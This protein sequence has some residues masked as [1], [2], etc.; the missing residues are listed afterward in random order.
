MTVRSAKQATKPLVCGD[1]L[2]V[3]R[4]ATRSATLRS[5]DHI[6][7]VD[8]PSSRIDESLQFVAKRF[9]QRVVLDDL[10]EHGHRVVV[11]GMPELAGRDR[12]FPCFRGARP[13]SELLVGEQVLEQPTL[14]LIGRRRRLNVTETASGAR[15]R[16]SLVEFGGLGRELGH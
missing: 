13:L 2:N 4:V 7:G 12:E 11:A 3:R 14:L 10:R 16:E 1:L 8:P 15:L 6:A 9:A 5:A